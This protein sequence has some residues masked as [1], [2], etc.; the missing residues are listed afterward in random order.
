MTE[1]KSIKSIAEELNRRATQYEINDLYQLRNK[2]K[3]SKLFT[4]KTIH[5]FYA[6]HYGGSNEIQFNIGVQDTNKGKVFR[7]GLAFS[8]E[9][10]RSIL[11]PVK[12]MKG[13][14]KSFND[15]YVDN[16]SFFKGVSL[17]G[18]SKVMP[19]TVKQCH[20]ID[21]GWI[22]EGNFIFIGK[23]FNKSLSEITS[24]DLDQILVF[25]DKLLELYKY[26][27]SSQQNIIQD[28][29][30][31][32][33]WNTEGWVLPSGPRGKSEQD[34]SYEYDCGYGH[35]EWLFDFDKLIEG[36]HYGFLQSVGRH[37]DKYT[38]KT[39]NINLYSRNSENKQKYWVAKIN[40]CKVIDR[41][42]EAEVL[43]IYKKQGWLK[44]ME[45]HLNGLGLDTSPF[46]QW[47]EDVGLFNIE[48]NPE[49]V[50]WFGEEL[51]PFD[52]SEEFSGNRYNLINIE[53]EVQICPIV[54]TSYQHSDESAGVD[55]VTVTGHQTQTRAQMVVE[56]S[57]LH[58]ELQ[59]AFREYLVKQYPKSSVRLEC[60]LPVYA[61]QIDIVR[62]DNESKTY[63]EV[64]TYQT[65]R[66]CI[67]EAIGQLLEY[68]YYPTAE[69]ALTNIIVSQSEATPS[70][71]KY[72]RYL[73]RKF[74]IPIGYIQF[75]VKKKAILQEYVF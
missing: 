56:C 22:K 69:R 16:P 75:S 50:D 71:I 38:G 41:E 19:A 54:D 62:Q 46:N 60:K 4:A 64:K 57:E 11:E 28:K 66:K 48:F 67:R 52:G 47:T 1:Y 27:E 65:A 34:G 2:K 55:T 15:F 63:Y 68:N 35:E 6:Y 18:S 70:D 42:K 10:T 23:Y 29:I 53:S 30:T 74:G 73:N 33:C 7:Y 44:Q 61:S 45:S 8:L 49:D 72:L 3:R 21:E 43:L 51:V 17:W 13:R 31:R 14:I 25:F 12:V 36:Y 24:R 26:V 40:N 39:F 5:Q 32:I 20:S 58:K 37:R 9:R 59:N